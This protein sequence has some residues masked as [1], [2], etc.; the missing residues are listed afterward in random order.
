MASLQMVTG[1]QFDSTGRLGGVGAVVIV[2]DEVVLLR[3]W[4]VRV[5][6]RDLELF[7]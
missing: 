7:E 5:V 2:G 1:V 4:L 3:V 6:V